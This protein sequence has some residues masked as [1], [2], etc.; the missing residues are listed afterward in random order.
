MRLLESNPDLTQREIAG[1]LG[2][3]LGRVNYC[4]R[5]LADKGMVKIKNF[6]NS[7]NKLGYLYLLT[8]RGVSQKVALTE[9]FLKRKVREY[10]ALKAEIEELEAEMSGIEQ[11]VARVRVSSD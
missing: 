9:S 7:N 8:P 11:P 10:E 4:L 6:R 2:V 1:H 3:S 5:A